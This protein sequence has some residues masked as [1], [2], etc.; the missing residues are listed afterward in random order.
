MTSLPTRT[1]IEVTIHV[2]LASQ[3]RAGRE[4]GAGPGPGRGDQTVHRAALNVISRLGGDAGRQ[5]RAGSG[6]AVAQEHRPAASTVAG[7]A[8]A[9]VLR[10]ISLPLY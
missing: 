4:C 5:V 9:Q 2:T 1:L 3:I 8:V 10:A 6:L 7:A